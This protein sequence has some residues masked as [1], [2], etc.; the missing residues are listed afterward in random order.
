MKK[1]K[2]V[3]IVVFVICAA[4][5]ALGIAYLVV[6]S[7]SPKPIEDESITQI[8][9]TT[10]EETTV[11]VPLQNEASVT[12]YKSDDGKISI[13]Y[14]TIKNMRD[15]SLQDL[16]NIKIKDN[17]LS[18]IK[19]YP[20]NSLKNT[21]DIKAQINYIDKKRISII[22]TGTIDKTNIFYTNT[23]DLE[24]AT[25][26]VFKDYLAPLAMA[27][28]LNNSKA[29]FVDA[30]VEKTKKINAYIKKNYSKKKL[31]E[32]FESAD[33][34]N[35][36]M[37]TWP[38]TFSYERNDSVFFSIKVSNALGDYVIVRYDLETK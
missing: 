5:L 20:I 9:T 32:M 29:T 37:K 25:N 21:C 36:E 15:T 23:I 17:A 8:E 16:I 14:P 13:E 2:A 18:I 38:K 24:N 4:V 27:S 35:E 7:F 11:V 26:V 34:K 28:L 3:L 22:Y 19:L 30:D 33:I 12:T 6:N 1:N 31:Q 10:K